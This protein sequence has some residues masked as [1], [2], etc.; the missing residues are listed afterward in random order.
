[1][2]KGPTLHLEFERDIIEIQTQ[3]NKLL[4]LADRR[5]LDVTEEVEGLSRRLEHLKR[6]TYQSL[7]PMQQVILMC[8]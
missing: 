6:E 5:G 4:D 8:H 1:M 3:I 2:S 7:E